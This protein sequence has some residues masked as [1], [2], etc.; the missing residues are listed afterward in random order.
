MRVVSSQRGLG[1]LQVGRKCHSSAY[2]IILSFL[3]EKFRKKYVQ[4]I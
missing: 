3:C 2:I 4:N 1:A